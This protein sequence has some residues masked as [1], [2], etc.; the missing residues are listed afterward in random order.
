M[1][2]PLARAA[3]AIGDTLN[4]GATRDVLDNAALAAICAIRDP[5]EAMILA[6]ASHIP[7][8]EGRR[9]FVRAW[10]AAVSA[11]LRE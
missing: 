4:N 10:R 11:M 7:G 2:E 5:S 8:S 6:G 1:T 3:S 9:C